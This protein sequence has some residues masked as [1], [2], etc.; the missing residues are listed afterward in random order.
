MAWW[1][2]DDIIWKVPL[3]AL[4]A[5]GGAAAFVHLVIFLALVELPAIITPLPVFAFLSIAALAYTLWQPRAAG[6]KYKLLG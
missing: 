3:W 6:G 5:L 2:R 1:W 4:M